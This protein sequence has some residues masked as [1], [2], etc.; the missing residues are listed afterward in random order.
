M[1]WLRGFSLALIVPFLCFTLYNYRP[2]VYGGPTI[3]VLRLTTGIPCPGCGLTRAT[4]S[5]LNGELGLSL[6]MHLLCIPMLT[7]LLICWLAVVSRALECSW[8][9]QYYQA[10]KLLFFSMIFYH[11]VR[12]VLFFGN[13]GL[14]EIASK[15]VISRLLN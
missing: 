9:P 13:G 12:L 2:T 6:E 10:T 7:Y 4:C 11:A 5:L 1:K 3:C 15:N 8:R 14:T